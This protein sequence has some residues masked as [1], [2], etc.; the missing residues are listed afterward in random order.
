MAHSNKRSAYRFGH[1]ELQA[2][3]RRLL[4]GGSPAALGPRAFDLLLTLVERPGRLVGKDELMALVWPGLVVEESN[5]QVQISTLRKILGR[6]AIETVS[7]HGYRLKLPVQEVPPAAPGLRPGVAQGIGTFLFTDIE[8]SARLWEEEPERMQVALA[9]HDAL[10]SDVLAAHA[11]T[12]VKRTGDGVHGVFADPAQA[13]AATLELQRSLADPAATGGL[14]LRVR[15]GLHLGT[16]EIREGDYYGPEVNRTARIMRAASGG[17]VLL[18]QAVAQAVED[19]L[20]EGASLRALGPIRLRGIAK[21]EE[22]YQLVDPDLPRDFPPLSGTESTPHNL[23]HPLTSFVGRARNLVETKALLA[24]ARLL[25][26]LGVGGLGKTRLALELAGEVLADFPDGVW[27]VDLAGQA[28]ERLVPHALARVIG[29]REDPGI[30][31]VDVLSR[32]LKERRTLLILD[33]C[34]HLLSACAALAKS[35]LQAAKGLRV[36]ATS[37]EPLHLAGETTYP[38]EPLEVPRAAADLSVVQC[39]SVRLFVDRARAVNPAFQLTPANAAP[40][41]EVCRQLDGIPLAIELA[42]ARTRMLSPEKIAERLEDRFRFLRNE[43]PTVLPRQQTLRSLIDWSYQALDEKEQALFRRL[44]VFAGGWTLE[45]CEAVVAG[46]QLEPEEVLDLLDGLVAKSLV[47]WDGDDERYRLL[48]TVREYARECLRSS[49]DEERVRAMHLRCYLDLA[50]GARPH[51][52][53]PEQAY[54]LSRLDAER[55]NL[56]AAYA[57]CERAPEGVESSL[58][59][60]TALRPYWVNRGL[61]TLGRRLTLEALERA[62]DSMDPRLRCRAL[63]DV[64]QLSSFMGFYEEATSWLEESLALARRMGDVAQV[65][66]VLQPLGMAYLGRGDIARSKLQFDEAVDLA[67]RLGNKRE[68]AAALNARA[69]LH[70]LEG[71][72]G[73]AAALYERVLELVRE[74]QDHEA[75]AIVLLN[76]AMMRTTAQAVPEARQCLA[77]AA[78]IAYDIGSKAVGQ[79][80][81]EVSAGLAVVASEPGLAARLYGA[82]EHQAQDS[83]LHRDAADEAFLAPLIALARTRLGGVFS[84]AENA[85]RCLT[86][87]DALGEAR[88]WLASR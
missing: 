12:M 30:P 15:C 65:A 70:R 86:Y 8:G 62:P 74:M 18:S 59:M 29:V 46:D 44:A 32:A 43:D 27:F 57:W 78:A 2:A 83:G 75:I 66:L 84:A 5:L 19:R 71:D 77:E 41:A 88:G 38:L 61:M 56:L 64:G 37:R 36:V 87:D 4:V 34:E 21:P 9:R 47:M 25:T 55:E 45:A 39:D 17:Q 26:L 35:L 31:L 68:L 20:P 58:R 24:Q 10:L 7:G 50:E 80:V 3:E 16:S 23:A 11:G 33:N 13:V 49:R 82:A 6:D 69:Q 76:L 63:F 72:V 60:M 79:S 53:G 73:N 51:L 48:D 52:A 85:G 1:C 54:W 14:P 22:V 67:A 40:I 81:L 42:A 28:D